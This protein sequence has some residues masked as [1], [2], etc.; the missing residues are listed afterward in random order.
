MITFRR[1]TSKVCSLSQR[2]FEIMTIEIDETVELALSI[3]FYLSHYRKMVY[4]SLLRDDK[5]PKTMADKTQE[6]SL[7]ASKSAV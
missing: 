5:S 4:I 6:Q 1:Y 2:K 3:F 7:T